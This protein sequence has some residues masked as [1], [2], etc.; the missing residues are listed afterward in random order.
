MDARWVVPAAI[1]VLALGSLGVTIKLALR[2]VT[3]PDV[4]VW[5]AI[6]YAATAFVLTALG[7]VSLGWSGGDRWALA[8]GALAVVG[9]ITL[10]LALDVAD[11]SRVVPA[12]A[13]YPVLTLLLGV[14][15]LAEKVTPGRVAGTLL[16]VLGVA[17]VGRS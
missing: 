5:T 6:V 15:V 8:S 17:L 12:T 4:L 10:Y 3:W 13:A 11:A 2:T 1:Y 7:R 16:I 9:I 14:A